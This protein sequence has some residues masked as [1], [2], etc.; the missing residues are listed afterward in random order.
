MFTWLALAL[1]A[2]VNLGLFILS[3]IYFPKQRQNL[4]PQP[5]QTPQSFPPT[6]TLNS[7]I[8]D[9]PTH[10]LQQVLLQLQDM[11]S[12]KQLVNINH[13]QVAL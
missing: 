2:T 4:V 3:V 13:K 5:Q 7:P 12:Q 9:Y 1:A 10:L 8:A 6:Q 11:V